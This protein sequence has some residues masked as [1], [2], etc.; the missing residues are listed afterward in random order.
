MGLHYFPTYCSNVAYKARTRKLV[1][2]VSVLVL[3]V[4]QLHLVP[5]LLLTMVPVEIVSNLCFLSSQD[6]IT[7]I[8]EYT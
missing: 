7:N 1:R 5:G 2:A 3:Q 4:V 8:I 6:C